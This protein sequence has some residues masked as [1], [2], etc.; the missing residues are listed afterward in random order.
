MK[1]YYDYWN[2]IKRYGIIFEYQNIGW[3]SEIPIKLDIDEKIYCEIMKKHNGL[4]RDHYLS[5]EFKT[6]QD[7]QNAIVELEPYLVMAKLIGE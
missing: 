7:A 6:E 5:F 4:E 3:T 1:L 2:A